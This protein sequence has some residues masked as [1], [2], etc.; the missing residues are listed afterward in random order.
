MKTDG[1]SG[2][3]MTRRSKLAW[4]MPGLLLL[5]GMVTGCWPAEPGAAPPGSATLDASVSACTPLV[6]AWPVSR[7]VE[8]LLMVAGQFSELGASKPMA[9]AGVGGFVLFGQP[10]A[11]S[12]PTIGSG[13]AALDAS[14]SAHGQIVP[15][16]STDEEGGPIARLSK[17]IGTLPSPRQMAAEWTPT[18]VRSAMTIHG[19]AMKSLGVT[20]DLA[21]VLDTASPADPVAGESYRSFSENSGVAASYG[22]AYAKGLRAAGVV[23]VAKHFPGLG[24][25]SANTDNGPATDPPSRSSRPMT[26]SHLSRLRWPGFPW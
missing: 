23:P 8:Q 17:V 14:A 9:A 2:S 13:I 1:A 16:M 6:N 21:P 20:M 15:W 3:H 11:G 18:Q 22:L 19:S 5:A 24:H 4:R 12:G 10:A 25:A 7:R 26:S